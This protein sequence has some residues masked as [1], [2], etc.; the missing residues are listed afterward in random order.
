MNKKRDDLYPEEETVNSLSIPG[1]W[2]QRENASVFRFISDLIAQPLIKQRLPLLRVDPPAA[3][4]AG[5]DPADYRGGQEV[6]IIRGLMH[7]SILPCQGR[8]QR[9]PWWPNCWKMHAKVLSWKPKHMPKCPLGAKTQT[10]ELFWGPKFVLKLS[11][12]AKICAKV[13]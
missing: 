11:Q 4:S 8:A 10:T 6:E 1:R 7:T 12:R 2:V 5:E 13:P 9:G 3:Y